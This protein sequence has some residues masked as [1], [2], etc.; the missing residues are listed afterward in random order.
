LFWGRQ[1][2]SALETAIQG[3]DQFSAKWYWLFGA[4]ERTPEIGESFC[5]KQ[6]SA[7]STSIKNE[8]GTTLHCA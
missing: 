1:S 7:K 6:E 5:A 2:L 3:H 4:T 8:I